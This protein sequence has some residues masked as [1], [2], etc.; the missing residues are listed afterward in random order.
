MRKKIRASHTRCS[1]CGKR[2]YIN[3][4]LAEKALGRAQVKY[5]R[6]AGK[7]GTRRGMNRG[8]RYYDN[9]SNS[10]FYLAETSWR[11]VGNE[12]DHWW[13]STM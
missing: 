3:R 2:G 6:I 9:F 7:A 1:S 12:R 11:H 5:N 4:R 10:L 13:Q 8:S